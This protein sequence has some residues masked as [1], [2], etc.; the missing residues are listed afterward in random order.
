MCLNQKQ[1][2]RK[3][4]Y[5]CSEALHFLR[6]WKRD[7][8]KHV[9]CHLSLLR[10]SAPSHIVLYHIQVEASLC[11]IPSLYCTRGG[12]CKGLTVFHSMGLGCKDLWD[13]GDL[14]EA[15][16]SMNNGQK[17]TKASSF[18]VKKDKTYRNELTF[19]I[20]PV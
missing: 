4:Y 7:L 10:D 19:L 13:H 2:D 14:R 18:C 16:I 9:T 3:D 20:A 12:L 11:I 5:I 15:N 6:V 8:R 1:T 17:I